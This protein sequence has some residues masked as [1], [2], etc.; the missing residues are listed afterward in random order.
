[1]N[2]FIPYKK[3]NI[4]IVDG[5]ID[6]EIEE[7]LRAYNTK[8]IKT[9]KCREVHES[10]S[11]HPDIVIHPI[12]HRTLMVAPNVYD[13]YKDALSP[14]D[15]DLIK[16]EKYLGKAYP[17]DIPYNVARL[18]NLAIHNFDYTDEKLLFYLKKEGLELLHVKQAYSKCSLALV[19]E[20]AGIT[21]DPQIYSKLKDL[22]YNILLIDHK[23]ID[24]EGQNYGFIG[25]TNGHISAKESLISGSLSLHPSRDKILDFFR[26]HEVELKFLSKKNIR[27]IAS[28]IATSA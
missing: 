4:L 16:G 15:I 27:D 7:N 22:N 28:I 17:K 5:S 21:S 1:M 18:G 26:V 3:P 23:H 14:Y 8:L 6:K 2:P 9:I 20:N 24:L 13:Y 10:I 11:Y 12:N 25:G 19:T